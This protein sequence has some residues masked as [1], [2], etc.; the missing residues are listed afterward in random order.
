MNQEIFDSLRHDYD[1]LV[2]I[3]KKHQSIIVNLEEPTIPIEYLTKDLMQSLTYGLISNV[4]ILAC[5]LRMQPSLQSTEKLEDSP[6][7]DGEKSVNDLD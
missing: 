7:I 1:T 6:I 5:I 3:L 2:D 4:N